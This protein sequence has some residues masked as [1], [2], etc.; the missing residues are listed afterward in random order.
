MP[1]SIQPSQRSSVSSFWRI[2][3]LT[4]LFLQKNSIIDVWQN[5]KHGFL[6]HCLEPW[7][8]CA[9]VIYLFKAKDGNTRTMREIYSK[10]PLMTPERCLLFL[11]LNGFRILLLWTSKATARER[12]ESYLFFNNWIRRVLAAKNNRLPCDKY[13]LKINNKCT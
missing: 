7:M 11:F 9:S 5:P 4:Y 10:L 1:L 3:V 13:L 8:T 2:N 12:F 6:L